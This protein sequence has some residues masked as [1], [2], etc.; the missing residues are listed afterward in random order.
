MLKGLN[1]DSELALQDSVVRVWGESAVAAGVRYV[2]VYEK[3]NVLMVVRDLE[4]FSKE[5]HAH[6]SYLWFTKGRYG[7]CE[8]VSQDKYPYIDSMREYFREGVKPSYYYTDGE[9]LQPY[10]VSE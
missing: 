10:F 5:H 3:H 9:T 2:S 1:A 8:A 4:K 6:L 7:A